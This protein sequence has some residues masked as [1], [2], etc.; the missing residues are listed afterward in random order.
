MRHRHYN[1][2]VVF[3]TPDI[4]SIPRL[5]VPAVK[6]PLLIPVRQFLSL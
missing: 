1:W 5:S 4:T 2:D 6:W 3:A